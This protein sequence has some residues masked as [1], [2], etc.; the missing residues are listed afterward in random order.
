[1]NEIG[2]FDFSLAQTLNEHGGA[3]GPTALCF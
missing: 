2:M 1:M 3:D